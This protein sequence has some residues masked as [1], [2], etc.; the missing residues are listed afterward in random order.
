MEYTLNQFCEDCRSAITDDEGDGGREIVRQK[1]E[2]LL[3]NEDFVA[4][5]C[6]PDADRGIHTL[7]EDQELGFV[8]LAHIYDKA[9]ESPPHDH[10]PS[11]AVYGQSVANTDMT[12]WTETG[13]DGDDPIVEPVETYRLDPGM[14]G[15]F[16]PRQIHSIK[17]PAGARFVR[18]TGTDLNT[19]AQ[20]RFDLANNKV[21]HS[22]AVP[23]PS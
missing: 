6:G 18:V 4:A 7:Y 10:G 8:V 3:A 1:L 12:I 23:R 14:A 20:R 15:T 21:D 5:N 11:W 22:K 17:F 2:T 16:N 9:V 19:V 13:K